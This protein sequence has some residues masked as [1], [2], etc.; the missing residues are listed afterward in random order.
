[1]PAAVVALLMHADK[2]DAQKQ[3]LFLDLSEK[4]HSVTQKTQ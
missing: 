4:A 3:M 2:T 1:M